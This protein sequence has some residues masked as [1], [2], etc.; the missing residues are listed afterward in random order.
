MAI[1]SKLRPAIFQI[2]FVF[3]R[4]HVVPERFL[5]FLL[6]K[7]EHWS[8]VQTTLRVHLFTVSLIILCFVSF[9]SRVPLTHCNRKKKK[10]DREGGRERDRDRERQRE[11]DR[12][13]QRE[14]DT[15]TETETERD[16]HTD[17]D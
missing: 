3:I 15:Q 1:D 11:T 10:K 6:Q 17:R 2:V 9:P 8:S 16:R 4:T 14:T 7:P 5:F 13:R 12:Q